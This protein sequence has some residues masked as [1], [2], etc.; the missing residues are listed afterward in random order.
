MNWCCNDSTL[1]T[2]SKSE[3]SLAVEIIHR[4]VLT[5]LVFSGISNTPFHKH[6]MDATLRQYTNPVVC[7]ISMLIRKLWG[8]DIEFNTKI[9]DLQDAL[10][11]DEEE[12]PRIMEL[13]H[14]VLMGAWTTSWSKSKTMSSIA[15]PTEACIALLTLKHD[16]SFKEPKDVTT[17]IAK[18]EYCM[19]L[20]FLRE[21]RARAS[22]EGM[23]EPTACNTL[24][25]W[26]TEKE[27]STFNRLRSLQHRASAIAYDT[28]GLPRIWWTDTETWTS[29][30]ASS[31][32]KSHNKT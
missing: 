21:I 8:S 7:L 27:Y 16:G 3:L 13:I 18:F 17:I 1:L 12:Q 2:L 6:M 28:M 32:R 19:R 14:K 31:G 26:F 30:R 22:T 23:D 25:C 15:D 11:S 10:S 29:L 24:Q 20:T 4:F 9:V 5:H